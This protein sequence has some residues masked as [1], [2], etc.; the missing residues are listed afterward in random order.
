MDIKLGQTVET[1]SARRGVVRYIGEVAGKDGV[2]AGLQLATPTGKNDGSVR[3]DRYFDCPPLHGVFVRVED[4]LRITAQPQPRAAT[5][6]PAPPKASPS[7]AAAPKTAGLARPRPSSIGAVKQAPAPATRPTSLVAPKPSTQSRPLGGLKTPAS[8]PSLKP[9]QPSQSSASPTAPRPSLGLQSSRPPQRPTTLTAPR[10]PSQILT[11]PKRQSISGPSQ[12]Y[13]ALRAPRKPSISAPAT[14]ASTRPGA[15]SSTPSATA[16]KLPKDPLEQPLEI[17][18]RQLQRQLD[19]ALKELEE[20]LPVK[21]KYQKIESVLGKVQNKCQTLYQENNSL[22]HENEQ[23]VR[24]VQDH[25][26]IVELAT[27]EKETAEEEADQIRAE[28]VTA[29]EYIEELKLEIEIRDD[30]SALDVEDLPE[31]EQQS[32]HLQRALAEQ[33]RLRNGILMLRDI[34]NEQKREHTARIAELEAQLEPLEDLRKEVSLLREED[35]TSKSII[36]DLREQVDAANEWE[37]MVEDITERANA[38]EEKNVRLAHEIRELEVINEVSNETIAEYVEHTNDLQAELEAR[39]S[40]LAAVTREL[41]ERHQE[42]DRLQLAVAKYHEALLFHQTNQTQ[43]EALKTFNEEQIKDITGRFNEAMEMNRQLHNAHV[44]NTNKAI[45]AELTKLSA[46]EAREELNIMK[47][48]LPES[49]AEYM[50]D[51]LRAYFRARKISAKAA[52]VSAHI[53]LAD[54]SMIEGADL[55]FTDLYRWEAVHHLNQI[56]FCG[57]LFWMTVAHCSLDEFRSIHPTYNMMSDVER[58]IEHTLER[59]R[60]DD[61]NYKDIAESVRKSSS[62]MQSLA[63]SPREMFESRPDGQLILYVSSM[64]SNLER[65]RATFKTV[66]TFLLGVVDFECEAVNSLSESID[67]ATENVTVSTK[68]LQ[69]LSALQADGLYP[70]FPGGVQE[71]EEKDLQLSV[72]AGCVSEFARRFT[73]TLPAAVDAQ[74]VSD[75][76]S[77]SMSELPL[78]M[79][80]PLK[81]YKAQFSQWHEYASVLMNTSEIELGP[82]PWELKAEQ[83]E[84]TRKNMLHAEKRLQLLTTEHQSLLIQIREREEVIDTKE[85]EIEHLRAKHKE[86]SHKASSIERLQQELETAKLEREKLKREVEEQKQELWRLED[87]AA[88]PPLPQPPAPAAEPLERTPAP[89]PDEYL[90]R[91]NTSS[92]FTTL[93]RALTNENHWLRRREHSEMLGHNLKDMFNGMQHHRATQA[94]TDSRHKQAQAAE[95]LHMTLSMHGPEPPRTRQRSSVQDDGNFFNDG[96]TP[97]WKS[98]SIPREAT[99]AA[100]SQSHRSPIQLAPI[101]TS[102]VHLEDLGFVDLSPVAEEFASEITEALEGFSELTLGDAEV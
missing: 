20:L 1:S 9:S 71:F 89:A 59:F 2:W 28:L 81:A 10:P 5:T 3:G 85:L 13:A 99:R 36:E 22:K 90:T 100:K 15:Q 52:I 34:A 44:S 72:Y 48:Y 35:V 56:G 101:Q 67:A 91:I 98:T 80:E 19:D 39:D 18:N 16:P 29:Q 88:Y 23:L 25:E 77:D 42:V 87:K 68:L 96:W 51:S 79:L 49:S 24:T 92:S 17:K 69:A 41:D 70:E 63:S 27:I 50:N 46:D 37:D 62:A 32:A 54:I 21:A 78:G 40:Q 82:A 55:A 102:F 97:D 66:K 6:K 76:I 84:A 43:A 86:A 73:A 31:E 53:S 45:A 4:I 26:S 38:L 12:P 58:T 33:H 65:I 11:Q 64:Q 95:M 14:S 94:R 8:R 83:M 74:A 47:I 57:K 75:T 30:Q 7:K 93:V 61:L 60:K